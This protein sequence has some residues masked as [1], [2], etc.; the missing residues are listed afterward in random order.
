MATHAKVFAAAV[1]YCI[2]TL[3]ALATTKFMDA[4]AASWNHDA[5]AHALHLVCTATA[6][7]VRELRD[8]VSDAM[9]AHEEL[10]DKEA[11]ATVLLYIPEFTLELLRK[12]KR[13]PVTP[14][15]RVSKTPLKS[16][17]RLSSPP[18]LVWNTLI[19]PWGP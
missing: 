17:P 6:S 8:I 5:F 9:L 7:E 19:Y 16:G 3:K 10:L 14:L 1:K 13:S 4:V 11:A 18:A 12:G 2:P 15:K